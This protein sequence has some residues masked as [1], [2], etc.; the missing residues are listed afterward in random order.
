M[1]WPR[2][3]TWLR[4]AFD[5][6]AWRTADNTSWNLQFDDLADYGGMG[7]YRSTPFALPPGLERQNR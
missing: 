7:L 3:A 6:S 5:D 4:P 1:R 2:P